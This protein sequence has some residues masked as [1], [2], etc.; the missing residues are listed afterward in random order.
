VRCDTVVFLCCRR[1]V[2]P[3]LALERADARIAPCHLLVLEMFDNVEEVKI[4]S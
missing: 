4:D 1:G 2:A 3:Y